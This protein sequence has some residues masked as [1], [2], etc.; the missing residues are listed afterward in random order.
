MIRTKLQNNINAVKKWLC[1]ASICAV[2][3][4]LIWGCA[5]APKRLLVKD[6]EIYYD[7]G[8]IVS[9]K[10]GTTVTFD[11]LMADLSGVQVIYVGEQHTNRAHHDIQLRIIK[12]AYTMHPDVIVGMEMFD[13]SYQN[14]LNQWSSDELDEETFLKKTHWYANWK[15]NYEYYKNILE[16]IQQENI[17]LVGLNV[18]NH[19]P[20]KIAVGGIDS[21]SA[22][23]KKYVAET[24]DTSNDAHRVYLEEVYKQHS[25]HGLDNFEFFYDYLAMAGSE[26]ES[27]YADYIWVTPRKN[28]HHK[29]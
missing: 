3:I 1:R 24:I 16:F 22:E 17:R 19:I 12:A 10:T 7:A 29:K 6:L 27:D 23:D 13:Q 8:T 28:P 2:V 9:T 26:V 11:E 18:P 20:R 25:V 4:G 5:V 14:I 21:L 15:Y